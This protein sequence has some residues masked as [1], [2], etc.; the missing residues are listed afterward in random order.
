VL[1]TINVTL[2]EALVANLPPCSPL[3]YIHAEANHVNSIVQ[4]LWMLTKKDDIHHAS[5]AGDDMIYRVSC[6]YQL[7]RENMTRTDTAF[8]PL[9]LCAP[10]ALHQ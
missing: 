9:H 1:P 7:L 2:D 5:F 3:D 10:D 4:A 6:I 8:D